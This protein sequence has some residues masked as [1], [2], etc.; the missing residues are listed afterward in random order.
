V[1]AANRLLDLELVETDRSKPTTNSSKTGMYRRSSSRQ[2]LLLRCCFRVA[3][4]ALSLR[5]FRQGQRRKAATRSRYC[6]SAGTAIR[7]MHEI[8]G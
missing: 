1:P 8:A 5:R 2:A 4:S 3:V 6:H 7:F